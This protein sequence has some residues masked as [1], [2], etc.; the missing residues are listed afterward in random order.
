VTTCATPAWWAWA[1]P[2]FP[3]HL[4]LKPGKEG[5]LDTLVINGAECE[6]FITCDDMLMRER[7]TDM[8]KGISAMRHMLQAGTC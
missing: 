6:P 8:L 7:A 3:S 1:A 4:K 2:C 5:S